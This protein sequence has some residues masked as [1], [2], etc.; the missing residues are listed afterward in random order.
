MRSRRATA[1]TPTRARASRTC[2]P[3]AARGRRTSTQLAS[4]ATD[5]SDA[6][7]EEPPL[8][9]RGAHHAPLRSPTTSIALLERAYAADPSI[10]AGRGALRRLAR[11][12]RQARRA[13]AASSSRSSQSESRARSVARSSRSRLRHALGLASPERRH[14]REVPRGGDQARSRERGRVPLPARRLRAQGRR[15]GSRAHARR[16]GGHA[17]GRERQRDVPPRAGGHDRVASAR[18]PDPRAHGVR[19]PQPDRARAPDAPRLR[20]A[21]RRALSNAP[22]RDGVASRRVGTIA[23]APRRPPQTRAAPAG[24]RRRAPRVRRRS[25]RGAPPTPPPRPSPPPSSAAV[26]SSGRSRGCRGSARRRR[27]SARAAARRERRLP[28]AARRSGKIAELRALADKQEAN[29]RYNEYVKT[30]L[31]LAAMRPRRGG[32]GRPLHEGR[33]ALHRQVR[34]PGRGREGLRG[35]HRH[36]SREP[37]RR[38]TTCAADVREASRLGEAPRSRAARSRA[39]STATSARAKFLEIAKL[40][41][42][43][44]KKPEVCIELW[45]EVLDSDP[46]NAEALGALGGLYERAKD[47]DKLVERAREAGRGHVRQ[48]GR[49]SRSSRKLGTIYGD[50]LNNDE[51]AVDGVACAPR[52]RPER[53]QGAGGA[54]EEVPHARSLGRPRGLLRRERQVG[55]VHPRP[56]AA[57]GEGDGRPRPRSACSSRSPSSGRTRSRRTIAPRAPTRRCSSS[58]RRTSRAAEALIP[59]YSQAG[60]SQGARQR[61]RGQ[62]RSRGGRVREAR[63]PARGRRPLRGQGQGAAEGVR[64]L[65]RRR[66]SSSPRTSRRTVDV[67][68]AAKAHRRVGR[69]SIAAYRKA[70]DEADGRGRRDRSRSRSA[71]KLGRVLVDEMKQVDE[72]LARLPRRLRRRQR[73]RRRDR[74]ARA[75]LP[76]DGALRGPPRHLREARELSPDAGEKKQISYEIAELYETELKDL[77]Q[78]DRHVQRRPRGRADGRAVR[79]PR[80]TCSTGSSSAGSRTSTSCAGA[81]S[82]TSTE[83]SSSTSSSASVRRSRSTSAT[84]PAR[85]RTTARSSSSTRST[86]A[87][88]RRSRRCSRTRT[89]RAE[90]A[91]ILENIYEERGDWEKLLDGARHPRARPRATRDRRVALL[92]KIA[93]ISSEMLNDLDA[94]VRG[95]RARRSRSSPRTPRR[96]REIER[97]AEQSRRPG[98]RSRSSTTQ[99]AE[100]LTDAQLARELLDA[101]A[102]RSTTAARP[103]RRSGEGLPARPLARPGGRRGARR[104]RDALL[105]HGAL[106]RSHRRHRASHRADGRSGASASSSTRRWRAIYDERLGRPDDAV[107]SYKRVLELDPASHERARRARRALHAPAACGAISPRTSRRS[108]RSRPTTRRRSRSCSASRRC[109]R[110]E[111]DAGR[112]GHRGLPPGPR[113]R[114]LERRGARRARASRTRAARTSSSSPT[115]SSRSTARSATTRSSSASTR[116]RSAAADDAARRVELLHQIA[117]LY[118]DAAADL[119]QR[120][121]HARARPRGGPG[122]R[123][124]AAQIDRVARATGRFADLAHGLSSSSAPKQEDAA[125]GSALI[126]M[127]A[128]V[129]EADIGDVDTAIGLYRK[130]LEIDPVQPRGGRVARAP[131]PPDGAL[132][133]PLAD[134]PAQGGDP[135]RAGRQ[136]GRAL[137]GRR[138]RGGRPR[139]ARGGDRRLPEGARARRGRPPRARRAH[140][141]LPR[142][143]ALAGPARRLL[144][145]GGPRRRS[146][147]RRS[148]STTRSAPSTSASSATSPQAIDTYHEDPRARS[149]RSPG[150]LASRRP[151]RAGAE[152]AGAPRRPQHESEMCED[153]DEAISFQYR[154]AEL[155]EKRLDDVVARDRALPRDPAAAGRSRADARCPRRA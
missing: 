97:I 116:C 8:P 10:E 129:Y 84:P 39:L 123:A 107:A 89:S 16:G 105:A 76:R 64:A 148:A 41:T 52:D 18:Q 109:A 137:P 26:A 35:G 25:G 108:S 139:A 24:L 67:E 22:P 23:A 74:R 37:R 102:R 43:R 140:Q 66:S 101:L 42:E 114:R 113:A 91:S 141:A 134:P 20:G 78:R 132:R 62:A 19:A 12:G 79:S 92:R 133:G 104:A 136:E 151:L 96:A 32:E 85:S 146:R 153:P 154:I 70:I 94:R 80:S 68:R 60:N 115:S 61:D 53:S 128:R 150:A 125:L 131:L 100:N 50:R 95:A 87:R 48:R 86:T 7:S 9:S 72:A 117:Q 135:R 56:R 51:G 54:Q 1:R 98:R 110:R 63:A 38:S 28:T 88:A 36:R 126:M 14:R 111:M 3:R 83:A 17:R 122:E 69:A 47:F 112:A 99:I 33:R 29:K 142:P 155:Y 73:E 145:E 120:V 5:E 130:V 144:E 77:D 46:A 81:S 138:H 44:V 75:P 119:E 6:A 59:I 40:A 45:H 118:E 149:R 34:E 4:A 147:T 103:G 93:R 152:L 65:P 57:G 121:R 82:S 143:V 71:C 124:D 30:L 55:R 90:A 27:G 2:R 106:D 127:S 13:R 58:S 15:L 11:R 49:R 21:D 31:Q